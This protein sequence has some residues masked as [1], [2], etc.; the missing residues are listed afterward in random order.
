MAKERRGWESDSAMLAE[1]ETVHAPAPNA[2]GP[3]LAEKASDSSTLRG[4]EDEKKV[5]EETG[6]GSGSRDGI[7]G[8]GEGMGGFVGEGERGRERVSEGSTVG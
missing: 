7:V 2:P 8:G 3:S 6:S 4:Q 5:V 1:E